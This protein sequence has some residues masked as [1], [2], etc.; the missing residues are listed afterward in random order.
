[1]NAALYNAS[2]S[3]QYPFQVWTIGLRSKLSDDFTFTTAYFSNTAS[4]AKSQNAGKSPDGW[5]GDLWYKGADKAKVGSWG[6]NV[7]YRNFKPLAID[8]QH[9]SGVFGNSTN[10]FGNTATGVYSDYGVK[11]WGFQANYTFSKNAILT[12][13]YETLNRNA[14]NDTRKVAPFYYLQANLY[15]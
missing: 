9:S 1:M 6:L 4:Y 14:S 5:Y 2:K 12:A 8:W 11:G 13:T 10:T 3:T 7:N 15:F